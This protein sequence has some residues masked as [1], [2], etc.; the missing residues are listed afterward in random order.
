MPIDV[1]GLAERL[2][3][4]IRAQPS[5]VTLQVNTDDVLRELQAIYPPRTDLGTVDELWAAMVQADAEDEELGNAN[6]WRSFVLVAWSYLPG[7]SVVTGTP[8][9]I[10]FMCPRSSWEVVQ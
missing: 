7:E 2:V 8:A 5:G 10:R 6:K 9:T 1:F 4:W 3:V